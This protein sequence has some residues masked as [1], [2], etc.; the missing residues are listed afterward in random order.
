[1][2]WNNVIQRNMKK[3]KRNINIR[4]EDV[5]KNIKRVIRYIYK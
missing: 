3:Y 5:V 2:W 1:M 4:K